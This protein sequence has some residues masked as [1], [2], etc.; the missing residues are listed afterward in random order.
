LTAHVAPGATQCHSSDSHHDLERLL[1]GQPRPLG[2]DGGA[3]DKPGC[4]AE[5][6]RG[7][8]T[9]EAFQT[10]GSSPPG[11]AQ[12]YRRDAWLGLMAIFAPWIATAV[13]TAFWWS[14]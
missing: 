6:R 1:Q 5:R 11:P 3:G 14:R 4:G 9:L 7:T 8:T 2:G 12:Y 13:V 10:N